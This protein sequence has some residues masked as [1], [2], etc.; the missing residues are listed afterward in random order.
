MPS[1]FPAAWNLART[2]FFGDPSNPAVGFCATNT[3]P[4]LVNDVFFTPP[5]DNFKGFFAPFDGPDPLPTTTTGFTGH[6]YFVTAIIGANG[7]GADPFPATSGCTPFTLVQGGAGGPTPNEETDNLVDHMPTGRFIVNLSR[8]DGNNCDDN[9]QCAPPH[10]SLRGPLDRADDTLYWKEKTRDR[11]NNF[12]IVASAGNTRDKHSGAIY[13]GLADSRFNSRATISQVSDNLFTFLNEDNLW[14]PSAR[15]LADGFTSFKP[16]VEEQA[17][18]AQDVVDAGM[19]G[20]DATADNVIVVGSAVAQTSDSVLTLHVKPEQ[21]FES[22]FSNSGSDVLAVGEHVLSGADL[23]GTSFSTPQVAGLVSYLWML[24]RDLRGTQPISVTKLAI[25]ANT[26]NRIIDAYATVLSLDNAGLPSPQSAPIRLRLLD[27]NQDDV[28]DDKDINEF[29]HQYFQSDPQGN[30]TDIPALAVID[31]SRY[32]LNGDGF[33]GG[34]TT[35]RFDLDREGSIQYG[36]SAYSTVLQNIGGDVAFDETRL[37]DLQ[38]L[39][40]YAYSPL[41]NNGA[42]NARD[43]LLGGR[44]TPVTVTVD[45]GQAAVQTG[46]TRQFS[47]TVHGSSDPRVTWTVTGSGN[48]IDSTGLLTAGSTAGTF[49][50]RAVSV[51]DPNA[52]AD[53]TVTVTTS[54]LL[55]FAFDEGLDGWT[56]TPAVQT[57][58]FNLARWLNEFGNVVQ[59][60][61]ADDAPTCASINDAPDHQPNSWISKSISLPSDVTTLEFDVAGHNRPQSDSEMRIRFARGSTSN[62]VLDWIRILGNQTEDPD[63]PVQFSHRTLNISS[64]AGQTVTVFFEQG[65]NGPGNNEQVYLDNIWFH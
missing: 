6:G 12:L 15:F 46:A 13:P 11:W 51:A 23:E 24:S 52:F 19:S 7:F 58:C 49:T 34:S 22:S 17:V 30:L 18:L 45:P 26:R 35:E 54:T 16:T 8:N 27:V 62:I 4:V 5:D 44:C 42:E 60:D 59:L 14:I 37:T 21:L 64:F 25:V 63:P 41:L 53:A 65:D 2:D 32:D 55:F 36:A 31:F 38:I 61:G 1:R 3:T 57:P 10:D 47:A 50:V 48:T 56:P 33:T 43:A 29:L 39:C 9:S 28:F 20:P 40:Y